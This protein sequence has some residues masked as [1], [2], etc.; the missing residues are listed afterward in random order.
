MDIVSEILKYITENLISIRDIFRDNPVFS[1]G[2]LLMSGYFISK[3]FLKIKLPP[4][5]GY[6]IAGLLLG[7]SVLGF[8]PHGTEQSFG[9]ITE[10]A[11]G[12]LS[13][14]IGTEFNIKKLKRTGFK[15]VFIS[16]IMIIITFASVFLSLKLI[17]QFDTIFAVLL[18]MVACTTAPAV[19][20]NVIKKLRVRG[21]FVDYVYGLVSISDAIIFLLFGIVTAIL[22]SALS[23]KPENAN[24]W[25][26]VFYPLIRLGISIGIGVLFGIVL[27]ILLKK[28]NKLNEILIL[29]LGIILLTTAIST[30]LRISIIIVNMIMGIVL[31]NLSSKNERLFTVRV[32]YP[33]MPPIYSLF[34][35][36]AGISLDINILIKP[37]TII[38]I[39]LFIVFRYIG[40]IGGVFLGSSLV[41]AGKNVRNYLG[42]CS[43]SQAGIA[44]C[45]IM[46]LEN[47]PIFIHIYSEQ[48][49]L[50][51]NIVLV[52]VL[53]NQLIGKPSTKFSVAKAVDLD[54]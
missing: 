33:L 9:I 20:L 34:F 22:F 8:I 6:I 15:V 43:L 13:V 46:V 52:A 44:I 12:I 2:L 11:I 27:N 21:V 30:S 5:T 42:F 51:V 23:I 37:F 41:G 31:I 17:L 32:M 10:I 1:V 48:L 26:T 38:A 54:I 28:V 45:L 35:A 7:E 36:L 18:S 47:S 49:N 39:L 14:A 24:S 4:I 16:I 25:N 19:T 50:I 40:K 53:I 29:G 3:L